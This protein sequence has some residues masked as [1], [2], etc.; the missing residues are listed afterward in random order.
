MSQGVPY[1]A[2]QQD[3]F[4][5]AKNLDNFPTQFPKS[6]AELC[7]WMSLLAYCDKDPDDDFVFD[8]DKIKQKL[9]PWGFQPTGFFESPGQGK[10]TAAHTA[11]SPFTMIP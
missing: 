9:A 11:S 1:S 10:K 6:D 8:R 3:L 5:P 4:Y 7:A 2:Q